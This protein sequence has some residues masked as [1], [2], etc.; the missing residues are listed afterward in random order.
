M[1]RQSKSA[2]EA[3]EEKY[4]LYARAFILCRHEKTAAL[5]VGIPPENVDEFLEQVKYSDAAM[6]IIIG[7]AVDIPDFKNPDAVREAVLKQLWREAK[8]SGASAGASRVSALK[9]IAEI[10]ALSDPE[11][12]KSIANK[13]GMLFVPVMSMDDWEKKCIKAQQTLR[14]GARD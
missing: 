8:T 10:A 14:A 2:R 5:G 4:V 12:A 11:D 9:A 6:K 1:A 3:A 13:G 7:D